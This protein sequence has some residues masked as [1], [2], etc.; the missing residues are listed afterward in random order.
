MGAGGMPS[1]PV[2]RAPWEPRRRGCDRSPWPT[3]HPV[4]TSGSW[5]L[6]AVGSPCC[7]VWSLC[8]LVLL[9]PTPPLCGTLCW[10]EWPAMVVVAWK[11]T[12]SPEPCNVTHVETTNLYLVVLITRWLDTK[13][14]NTSLVR[15]VNIDRCLSIRLFYI[16]SDLI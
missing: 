9:S 11:P 5:R 2:W 16:T 13:K 7:H 8:T 3:P 1:S 10:V 12:W 14:E 4:A 15:P 6:A